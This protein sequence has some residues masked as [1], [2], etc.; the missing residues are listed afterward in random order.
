MTP[1][2]QVEEVLKA[3]LFGRIERGIVRGEGD[4][5]PAVRRLVVAGPLWLRPVARF[6]ARREARALHRLS[7]LSHVPHLI[8]R[9]RSGPLRTFVPGRPLQ[10]VAPTDPEFYAQARRLL[11][12]MHRKGV[13]HNDTHKEPNWLVDADGQPALLDFQLASCH[14]RRSR[15]FRLCALEDVRHLLKHKRKYCP[16]ALTARERRILARRSWVARLW[17]GTVKRPYRWFT[18]RVLKWRDDEGRGM[19]SQSL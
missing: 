12:R 8:A 10:E 11:I 16:E 13:T 2:F 5:I 17:G 3:D 14:P 6:L 19:G 9:D 7:G 18:R 15:W 1:E 4:P